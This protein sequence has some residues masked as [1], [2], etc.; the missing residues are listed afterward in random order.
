MMTSKWKQSTAALAL[1]AAAVMGAAGCGSEPADAETMAE[2]AT[3]TAMAEPATVRETWDVTMA[4]YEDTCPTDKHEA[5]QEWL[6]QILQ[7][8]RET[9]EAMNADTAAGPGFYTKAYV[10]ID[11]VEEKADRRGQGRL[12]EIRDMLLE[13]VKDLNRWIE[14][15]PTS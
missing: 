8:V 2:S 13:D 5:R 9:R 1:A 15:H 11:D 4:V 10:L 14:K 6:A 3:E 7:G 12:Y